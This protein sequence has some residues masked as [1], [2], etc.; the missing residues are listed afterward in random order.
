M[1]LIYYIG[2]Y[3]NEWHVILNEKW[4]LVAASNCAS[5]RH[6]YMIRFH[7]RPWYACKAIIFC[8][9]SFF[10]RTHKTQSNFA[11]RSKVSQIWKWTY[12]IWRFLP[13][14]RRDQ[15]CLFSG[16]FTTT[17]RFKSKHLPNNTSY[18][19]TEIPFKPQRV[20]DIFQNL[21]NLGSQTAKIT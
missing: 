13:I 7:I 2:F 8:R 15:K 17:S 14:K 19:Q 3:H 21:V 9:R 20:P 4:F 12:T 18:R 1:S 5:V 6:A 16:K 10:F 11:T